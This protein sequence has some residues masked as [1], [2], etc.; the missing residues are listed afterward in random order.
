M[1]SRYPLYLARAAALGVL[2]G[3]LTAFAGRMDPALSRLVSNPSCLTK[4]ADGTGAAFNAAGNS[5]CRPD[6]KAFANLVGELSLAI[7][8]TAMQSARSIGMGGFEVTAEVALTTISQNESYWKD[9][10]RG[11]IDPATER[12]SVT[13]KK[14]DAILQ[15]WSAKVR[16]GFPFGLELTGSVGWLAHTSFM[17][18]GADIRWSMLEGFRKGIPAGFPEIGIGTGVRTTTGMDDL[19]ITVMS[20]DAQLS[21]QLPIA[22]TAML[23]PYAGYQ[24]LYTWGD[25]NQ[26]DLT[27]NTDEVSNCGFV[28][29]NS[30]ASPDA[31]KSGFDGQPVCKDGSSNDFNNST[32]FS[33][34]RMMRHRVLFGLQSKIQMVKI[35]I[36]GSTDLLDVT[37]ANPSKKA[38]DGSALFAKVGRQWTITTELGASF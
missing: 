20:A 14:P 5:S 19:Q 9:G 33:P 26:V 7:A 8:P 23:M 10:T 16:K 28:G 13:N 32:V 21:K 34:V 24:W 30:P 38:S 37:K 29:T 18:G 17:V 36:Q 11:P 22:G 31:D 27:P 6:N 35:G 3:P 2:I 1:G 15:T 25:T 12:F 4:A